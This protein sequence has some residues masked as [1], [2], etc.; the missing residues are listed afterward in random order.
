MQF[1]CFVLIGSVTLA[2]GAA[3]KQQRTLTI[4]QERSLI[5]S[6][7]I[8]VGFYVPNQE[9][10]LIMVE[11]VK[12]MDIFL[13]LLSKYDQH[14]QNHEQN[15]FYSQPSRNYLIPRPASQ[16]DNQKKKRSFASFRFRP[17]G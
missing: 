1:L 17:K 2:E 6:N 14:A 11:T 4:H 12:D 7:Q 13:K 8:N 16:V 3:Y 10:V 5:Q 15:S 9:D